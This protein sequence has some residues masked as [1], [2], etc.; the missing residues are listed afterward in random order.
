V[1]AARAATDYVRSEDRTWP[2]SFENLCEARGV[3][4]ASVRRELGAPLPAA[5]AMLASTRPGP[6]RA[7]RR[8]RVVPRVP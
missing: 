3:N 5:H 1:R 4:A 8:R 7:A 6:R 2:F